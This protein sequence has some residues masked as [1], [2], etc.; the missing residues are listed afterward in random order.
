MYVA[1]NCYGNQGN[2]PREVRWSLLRGSKKPTTALYICNY[3]NHYEPVTSMI[4]SSTPTYGKTSEESMYLSIYKN[5][6]NTISQYVVLVSGFCVSI[7]SRVVWERGISSTTLV[8]ISS[9]FLL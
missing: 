6:E 5:E 7:P 2:L 1:N 9:N 4:D 3:C 8:V